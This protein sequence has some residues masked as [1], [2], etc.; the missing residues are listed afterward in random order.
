MLYSSVKLDAQTDLRLEKIS[1]QVQKK[2]GVRVFKK[3]IID[4]AVQQ[5]EN[6]TRQQEK[7]VAWNKRQ[8]QP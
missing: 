6:D 5:L 2:F 3:N 4:F 1:L 7:M 8:G